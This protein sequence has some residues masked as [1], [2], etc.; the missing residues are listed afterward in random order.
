[1][2]TTTNSTKNAAWV[3]LYNIIGRINGRS[4]AIA[5]GFYVAFRQPNG[6]VQRIKFERDEQTAYAFRDWLLS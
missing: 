4:C 2:N 6:G 3:E 5:N 1:M